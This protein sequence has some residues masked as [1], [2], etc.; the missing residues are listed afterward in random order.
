MTQ[1]KQTTIHNPF[2]LSGPGLHTGGFYHATVR[3]ASANT[4]IV[5]R[6][7]DLGTPVEIQAIATAVVDT[8]HGTT[9]ASGKTT[10]STIEHMMSAF[11]GMGID[12]AVV[13]IDGPEIPI[14]DGSSVLW[15]DGIRQSGIVELDCARSYLEIKENVEWRDDASGI[16]MTATPADGFSV[17]CNIRFESSLIGNQSVSFSDFATYPVEIAPCRTFVFLHEV[18]MLLAANLIKGGDLDNAL[19][20]V[21]KPLDESE[22]ESLARL[23]NKDKS[24]IQVHEG[25]LN[26]VVPY[27]PNEPARHKMLDFIGDIRLVGKPLKGHFRL[28]C[29]GHRA[30]VAL[31]NLILSKI[32]KN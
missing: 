25:V 30:N 14:L 6:R 12:N 22:K 31:A 27:F 7:T 10:V 17:E 23:F 20:F 5:I 4:G 19:V 18:K 26:T 2:T 9:V 15:V 1:E 16:I 11:H 24:T 32:T 21:D 3:P 13:D 29:P 8:N 28:E